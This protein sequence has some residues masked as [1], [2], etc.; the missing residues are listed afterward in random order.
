M[1]SFLIEVREESNRVASQHIKDA[2]R[3]CGSHF[4]THAVWVS[5]NG[6]RVGSMIA[7]LENKS[8]ALSIVPPNMR[9]HAHVTS[10][11]SGRAAQ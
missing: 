7:E 10:I 5:K 9:A 11:V 3:Q 8:L 4:A 6:S 1:P 2:V